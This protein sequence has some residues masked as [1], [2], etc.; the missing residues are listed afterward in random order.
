LQRLGFG[1]GMLGLFLGVPQLLVEQIDLL[2]HDFV[3]VLQRIQKR[4]LLR[5][6]LAEIFVFLPKRGLVR[7]A[8]DTPR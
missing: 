6:L 7:G 5:Q 2:L 3:A 4:L 1:L 8:P